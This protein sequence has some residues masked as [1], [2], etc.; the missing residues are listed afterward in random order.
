MRR[1]TGHRGRLVFAVEIGGSRGSLSDPKLREIKSIR[2]SQRAGVSAVRPVGRA[3]GRPCSC[4]ALST[5]V[6]AGPRVLQKLVAGAD[7]IVAPRSRPLASGVCL[8]RG[9]RRTGTGPDHLP[10]FTNKN[11]GEIIFMIAI[12]RLSRRH[13][14]E[15]RSA[16]SPTTALRAGATGVVEEARRQAARSGEA[17]EGF[18]GR[19]TAQ[20]AAVPARAVSGTCHAARR[21][22]G[23]Q[24]PA[25]ARV[26]GDPRG[27]AHHRAAR[28]LPHRSAQHSAHAR[29]PAGG[30]Q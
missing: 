10:F 20:G 19:I 27:H 26:P 6:T 4:G 14:H 22:R 15:D 7:R 9:Q 11:I 13:G 3:P 24:P 5:G 28:E 2:W 23:G 30:G 18:A 17:T 8:T 25:A 21:R 1:L 29:A 12:Q 16:S